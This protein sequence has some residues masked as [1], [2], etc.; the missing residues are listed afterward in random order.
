MDRQLYRLLLGAAAL[1]ASLNLHAA[2]VSPE[3]AVSLIDASSNQEVTVSAIA[4]P[5]PVIEVLKPINPMAKLRAAKKVAQATKPHTI[6]VQL[7]SRSERQQMALLLSNLSEKEKGKAKQKF[8]DDD[9]DGDD[10]YEALP[11]HQFYTRPRLVRDDEPDEAAN[12]TLFNDNVRLRLMMARLKALEAHAMAQVQDDGEPLPERVS[13]RLA[14][15]RA[16]AL[17][18]HAELHSS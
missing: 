13:N 4:Q 12:I 10:G 3:E 2:D 11:L 17:A 16:K 6:P 7:L 9:D 18:R 1:L 8:V 5:A 14:E 15:A